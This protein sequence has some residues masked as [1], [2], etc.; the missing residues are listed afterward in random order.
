MSLITPLALLLLLL[1][2][3][4][5]YIG[6]PRVAF[7]RRRD[8]ASLILRV[9]I[10][11][12]L[13]LALAGA[14]AVQPADTL[15]VVFLLD[16]SDSIPAAGREAQV[17][18]LRDSLAA[19]PPD[20]QAAIVVFG[21]NALVERPM[22]GVRELGPLRSTPNT[23]N[24]DL[25][26]A[27]GL[28]L[29]LFPADSAR[30]MVILSDGQPTIGDAEAAVRRAAATDVD[31]RYVDLTSGTESAI[32][33]VWVSDVRVPPSVGAGQQFDL[34]LTVESS[35]EGIPATITVLASGELI[36]AQE[37]VLQQGGNRYALSLQAGESGFSDF[38]VQV[39]PI[40]D[41]RFYQNNQLAAFNRVVG[42]PR[43]L[44]ISAD[45]DEAQ[46]LAA[47]LEE[48]GLGVDLS[49][50]NEL[51]ISLP[52][53]AS[54][55]TVMLANVPATQLTTRRMEL[56]QR[57]VRDLG[58][59]LVTVGGPDSYAA[60]GY[61]LTPLEETLPLDMQIRDQQRLPQ[62]T[63]AYV[64][65]RSGS[66]GVAGPGGVANI[67]LAKEAIIRSIEFLQPTDRAGLVSFDTAGYWIA[68][69]QPVF[70][71]LGLQS[72]AGTLR[73][74]G[75]TDILAGLRLAAEALA[76]DPAP[77]K[78]IILLTDGGATESG[79]VELTSTL[80]ETSGVTTSVI[81]IGGGAAAFLDDMAQ[82]GGGQYHA[83]TNA[84]SIP[85]IFTQETVLATRSYL[86][87]EEFTAALS[88]IHPIMSGIDALP[89]LLGYVAATPKQTAQVILRGPEPYQDPIL[90][91]WQY[92]LGRAVA[93]TSD[94]S[95][96]WS[97]NWAGWEGFARFWGQAARWTITEGVTSGVESR[98]V[99][100]GDRARLIVDARAVDGS[101]LNGLSLTASL[102]DPALNAR[103]LT[104]QQVAPGRYEASFIPDAEGAYFL[105]LS[106]AD[107]D[108]VIEQT[109]GWVMSYSQEYVQPAAGERFFER[110][111]TLFDKTEGELALVDPA[112]AFTH[113]L[114]GRSAQTPLWP[115]LL[116]AAL[117]LLPVDIA[118][119]RLI[120]T[121][122]DLARV[123]AYF[124]R[125]RAELPETSA[126]MTTLL[127]AKQRAQQQTDAPASEGTAA[128]LRRR[129]EA[130][131][132]E[133]AEAPTVVPSA[134]PADAPEPVSPARQPT[135]TPEAGTLAGR[136]LEKRKGREE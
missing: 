94:A 98:V 31:L 122:S 130:R 95:A 19:M 74:S 115:Y 44:L 25:E 52:A 84:E 136:L 23:G 73:A 68:E 128:A 38:R 42:A 4:V 77:R 45:P 111:E 107:G 114:A 14:Q 10:L 123:R 134:R 1:I 47:A 81:A 65:D 18:Y 93:F 108:Q 103:T 17:A 83:V 91:A 21:A 36:H 121:P 75:G 30:R 20:D 60:G 28:G 69:I 13:T 88:A 99:M 67:E 70:D 82:A 101:F 120:I 58:G 29:A 59:G 76:D 105:R 66:M 55:S 113:D 126:R 7:R 106:G 5:I 131:Q 56:L 119:R 71:R 62:L 34:S 46:Y 51:P 37:V 2:P 132:G 87:E 61:F 26:E 133:R 127:G 125:E 16:T 116:I 104:L 57:Y 124:R 100:E 48:Q 86:I 64:I 49:T 80:Y 8:L 96:R 90:A 6:W 40:A 112:A 35:A 39:E 33:D 54:Y 85:T 12:L 79:L 50:P 63:I 78:H 15:A 102:V 9:L 97:A 117:L 129:R 24:T 43:V 41:D 11:L 92:G 72:L 109:S 22:S 135:S 32:A 27:I 110:L 118:V 89:P 3:L 53:L